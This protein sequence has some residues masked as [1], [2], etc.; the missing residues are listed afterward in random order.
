MADSYRPLI[1]ILTYLINSYSLYS[2]FP[3]GFRQI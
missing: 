2:R 1:F 3:N